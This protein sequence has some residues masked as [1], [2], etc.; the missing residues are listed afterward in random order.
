MKDA[1]FATNGFK[2]FLSDHLGSVSL[3]L[4]TD[5]DNVQHVEQQRYLPFG[6]PRAMPPFAAITS[7]DFTYTGQRALPDTGLMDY[8]ARFYSPSLGRFIQPDTIIPSAENPQSWNR[9]TYVTNNPLGYM[10]PSGHGQCQTQE[11]CEDMGTTPMG[12]G[13]SSGGNNGGGGG[14]GDGSGDSDHCRNDPDCLLGD[15]SNTNYLDFTGYLANVL[16]NRIAFLRSLNSQYYIHGLGGAWGMLLGY[17][18]PGGAWDIKIGMGRVSAGT[19]LCDNQGMCNYYDYSTA[20]NIQLGYLVGWLHLNKQ[21]SDVAGGLVNTYDVI[22]GAPDA[23][24]GG[25]PWCDD[26]RDQAAVDFGYSL[27]TNPDYANGITKGELAVEL[28]NS[29]LTASFQPPPSWWVQPYPARPGP[30][31]YGSNYFDN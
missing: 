7:T 4:Y 18:Y 30:T 26:P 22:R 8:K 20:G 14:S 1:D 28:G 24:Y 23:T 3:V 19:A 10:D 12:G 11:D 31:I 27:G 5:H 21:L 17:E 9:F 16:A 15:D 29:P 25:C 6:Q 13:S 2:Y